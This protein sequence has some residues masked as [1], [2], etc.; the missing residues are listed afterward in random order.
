MDV[1]RGPS[2]CTASRGAYHASRSTHPCGGSYLNLSHARHASFLWRDREHR[3]HRW[4][5]YLKTSTL[6]YDSFVLHHILASVGRHG[7]CLSSFFDVR[8]SFLAQ[9]SA[10][11]AS[12]K[13][14]NDRISRW[15]RGRSQLKDLLPHTL[16][17]RA[18]NSM[19]R[20]WMES[21]VY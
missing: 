1:L 2:S 13:L 12:H 9:N 18:I 15:A 19:R 3:K 14:E 16:F 4:P 6:G 21:S 11:L 5:A 8:V 17:S 10:M 20:G 7:S